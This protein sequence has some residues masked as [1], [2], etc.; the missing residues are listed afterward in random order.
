MKSVTSWNTSDRTLVKAFFE[1]RMK[2]YSDNH[3]ILGFG[4]KES[5]IVRYKV[6]T[7]IGDLRGKSI[8]DYGCGLGD[9][10]DYLEKKRINV[11]YTGYDISEKII[12]RAQKLHPNHHFEVRDIIKNV[13]NQRFSYLFAIG[14]NLKITNNVCFIKELIR[15]MFEIAD[16]GVSVSLLSCYTDYFADE[17]YY[18]NPPLLFDWCLTNVSKR[19]VLR[20]DYLPHDFTLYIYK[21][22]HDKRE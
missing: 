9:F 17:C 13:P 16:N 10:I 19:C 5:Q 1:N 15:Q 2:K 12:K 20:H 18:H 7:E 21:N 4:S 11:K 14:L 6:A 8:L 3:R 22:Q